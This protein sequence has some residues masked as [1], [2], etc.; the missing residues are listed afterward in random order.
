MAQLLESFLDN[1]FKQIIR[2]NSLIY[3]NLVKKIMGLF[4]VAYN[5]IYPVIPHSRSWFNKNDIQAMVI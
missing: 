3:E 4:R 1:H 2:T 5:V